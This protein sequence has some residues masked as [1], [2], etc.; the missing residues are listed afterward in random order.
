MIARH[1]DPQQTGAAVAVCEIFHA[2]GGA[3]SSE[4]STEPLRSTPSGRLSA[5]PRGLRSPS[6]F[7][8]RGHEDSSVEIQILWSFLKCLKVMLNEKSL[9]KMLTTSAVW[10]Y[11]MLDTNVFYE[12]LMSL[13]G[14][15][16]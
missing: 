2:Y 8:V 12:C 15:E 14:K 16:P 10:M 11:G 9:K 4:L 3:Q 13:P 7:K 6:G 5:A 1:Y